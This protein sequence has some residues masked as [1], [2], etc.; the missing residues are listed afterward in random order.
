MLGSFLGGIFL[1]ALA[2]INFKEKEFLKNI[3]SL[4]GLGLIGFAIYLAWPK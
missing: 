3:I 4:L 1:L 2:R